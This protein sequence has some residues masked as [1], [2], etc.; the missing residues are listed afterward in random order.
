MSDIIKG[1]ETISGYQNLQYCQNGL[2]YCVTHNDETLSDVSDQR[3]QKT[4][5]CVGR[6]TE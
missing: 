2:M 3:W 5:G 4:G 1:S 6:P